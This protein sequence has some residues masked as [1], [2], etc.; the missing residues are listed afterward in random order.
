MGGKARAPSSR[1]PAKTEKK[2][3]VKPG[4]TTDR[5]GFLA[6]VSFKISLRRTRGDTSDFEV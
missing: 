4:R 2:E 3:D 1:R 6:M 5:I